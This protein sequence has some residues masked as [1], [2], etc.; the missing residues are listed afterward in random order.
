MRPNLRILVAFALV[1]L[2]M[3]YLITSGFNSQTMVYYATVKELKMQGD[4]A[5]GRGFRVG[6]KVVPGSVVRSADR[7]Q[8]RFAIEEDGEQLVV[9]YDGVLPDTFREEADVLVEG[10]ML[11]DH[12]FQATNVFTKCASKYEPS[13]DDKTD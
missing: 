11:P 10:K 13:F 6:G 1:I 4:D 5:V 8:V 12:T 3:V 9:V 7:V 2:A